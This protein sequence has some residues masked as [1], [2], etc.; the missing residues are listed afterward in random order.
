MRE[1]E[2]HLVVVGVVGVTFLLLLL[3]GWAIVRPFVRPHVVTHP[4]FGPAP[5]RVRVVSPMTEEQRDAIRQ[6]QR[7]FRERQRE[8]TQGKTDTGKPR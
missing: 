4:V 5:S 2:K 8:R 6:R 7:E 1:S 3:G